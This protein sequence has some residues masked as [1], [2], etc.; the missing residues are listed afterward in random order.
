MKEFNLGYPTE[1]IMPRGD[2]LPEA[3]REEGKGEV[4]DR[5]GKGLKEK[6]EG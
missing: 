5:K 1:R 4:G 2:N 6:G 3:K